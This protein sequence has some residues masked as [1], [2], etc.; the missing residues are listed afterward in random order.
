M[1]R[2]IDVARA[3]G[4]SRTTASNVFNNPKIVRP[5]LRKRVEL[6]AKEMGYAGPDPKGRLLREGKYNAIAVMP[7]SVWNVVDVIRNPVMNI[8]LQGI[9]EI[10]DENGAN[11]VII[12]GQ[13]IRGGIQNALVDGVIFGRVDQLE[14]IEPA[15]LR[16]IPFAVVDFDPGPNIS[17]VG[18]DSRAGAY[19]AAK[20]LVDLGHRQFAIFSFLREPGEARI[21][22]AGQTRSI[23][24]AGILMDQEK[25]HGYGDA[26]RDVGIDIADVPMIQ[27]D[28]YDS[29][30]PGMLLELAPKATAILSMSVMQGVGLVREAKKRGR[31]V[32]DNL[33][34]VGYNDIPDAANC[35]PPLTTVDS[36]G[37]QKGREAARLVFGGGPPQHKI[38]KPELIIRGSTAPAPT[39]AD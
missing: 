36:M 3:A 4:V 20:H 1:A 8:F 38:L 30:A 16:R 25:Y 6:A 17:S 12:S 5:K 27:G 24:A 28:A 39:F 15:R 22:P 19:A 29:K 14:Q 11:L 31:S 35:I 21:Y 33:S 10:C 7:P 32:P 37:L 2:L 13:N 9:G 34:V 26:L 18:V 23:E